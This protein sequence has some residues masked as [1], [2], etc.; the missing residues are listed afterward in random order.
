MLSLGICEKMGNGPS[1]KYRIIWPIMTDNIK[2]SM[3][4]SGFFDF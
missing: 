3:I 4:N 1:T 2:H